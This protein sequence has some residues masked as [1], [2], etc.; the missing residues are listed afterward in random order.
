MLTV[1]SQQLKHQMAACLLMNEWKES[2]STFGYSAHRERR[3]SGVELLT[4]LQLPYNSSRDI[5]SHH[6][7]V[8][9]QLEILTALCSR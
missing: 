3:H 4:L 8:G 7:Y 5:S 6:Q 2:P 1:P 9:S